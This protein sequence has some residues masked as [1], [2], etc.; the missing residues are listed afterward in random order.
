M[1]RNWKL[2]YA[3]LGGVI[4]GLLMSVVFH[5][6]YDWLGNSPYLAWFFAVNESVWEHGKLVFYPYLIYSIIE[7]FIIKPDKGSYIAA[8]SIALL[9]VIPL[10]ITIFYTYT[11]IIGTHMLWADILLTLVIVFVSYIISYRLL[12]SGFNLR[13]YS[14]FAIP[15]L[16]LLILVIVFTYYPPHLPLFLDTM[17]N[18]YG[19]G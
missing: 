6:S 4:F 5:F 10:M 12:N 13:K 1:S 7:Y 14:W 16:I 8:K 11:G 3:E 9:V 15:A 19:L 17:T 2:I 18:T